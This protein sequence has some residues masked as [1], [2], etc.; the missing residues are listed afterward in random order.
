MTIQAAPVS[1][2]AFAA[3]AVLP[4]A[5]SAAA[6][7]MTSAWI[8]YFVSGLFVR[9]DNIP[10]TLRTIAGVFPVKPLFEALVIAY[11]PARSA[12]GLV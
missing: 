10:A 7:T 1:A 3:T 8:L 2:L 11:A 12:A 9:E 6:L 5:N 4:T